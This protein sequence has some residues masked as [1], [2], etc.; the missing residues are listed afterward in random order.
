MRQRVGQ[1]RGA[2]V[3]YVLIG[4]LQLGERSAHRINADAAREGRNE[5]SSLQSDT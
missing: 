2:R 3:R 1:R 4:E 5:Q